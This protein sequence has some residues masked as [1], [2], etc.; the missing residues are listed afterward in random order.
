M[1]PIVGGQIRVLTFKDGLLSKVAHDLSLSLERFDVQSDGKRVQAAM[2]LESLTVEGVMR[3]GV[4]D[5]HGVSDA[6]RQD[7]VANIQHKV[8]HTDDD[9][10]ASFSGEA[11]P[12][13]G[14]Y[15]V[16]GSL[17]LA[18]KSRDLSFDVQEASGCWR[19]ELELQPSLWG[20]KP[21]KALMG[22]IKLQDRVVVR[23]ELPITPL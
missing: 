2:Q 1:K 20:I 9:P 12:V 16:S 7:I 4:L 23:V 22:A 19:G 13:A 15:R 18:G 6:D 10:T 3:K 14:G 17:T 8:L 21:F 5:P 11:A